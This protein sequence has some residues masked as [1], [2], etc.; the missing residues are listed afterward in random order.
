MAVKS[1]CLISAF[2]QSGIFVYGEVVELLEA[3][4]NCSSCEAKKCL[5][6]CCVCL[7]RRDVKV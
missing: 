1:R 3:D 2:F 5:G 4:I 6:W 7:F